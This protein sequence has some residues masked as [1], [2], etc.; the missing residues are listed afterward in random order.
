MH[1]QITNPLTT[2]LFQDDTFTVVHVL[3]SRYA[4]VG[5][6]KRHPRDKFDR[7]HGHDVAM[8]RALEDLAAQ[9]R[10]GIE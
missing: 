3:G 2:T 10:A 8:A 4:A 6:A 7:Q 5:V 9:V 1:G